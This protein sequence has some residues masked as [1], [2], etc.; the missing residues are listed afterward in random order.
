MNSNR[1]VIDGKIYNSVDEMPADVRAKYEQAMRSL[2][3]SNQN[4]VPD[5]MDN[6]NV[7]NIFKDQNGNGI[8]DIFENP[9]S[10]HVTT[11]T[12]KFV[13]N[14]REYDNL[15]DLPADAR[16][17]Y[18]KAMGNMD[19]NRNGIPDFAEDMIKN[20]QPVQSQVIQTTTPKNSSKPINTSS[21]ITPDTSNGW[22]LV[23]V[24]GLLLSVCA[25]G[26]LGV[27]YFLIR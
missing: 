25:L 3:D 13:V 15:E 20:V 9:S 26:A 18:E 27:W 4:G 8:P 23:L 11:N 24:V 19:K 16:A 17:K 21:A 10:T 6:V 22:M 7:A 12:T 14:G 5:N 1:I 2:R